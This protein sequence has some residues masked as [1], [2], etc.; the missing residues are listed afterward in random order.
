MIVVVVP[1]LGRPG[2]AA[3]VAESLATST[4]TP[5]RLVWVCSPGDTEQ[6]LACEQAGGEILMA[7]WEPGPGDF[8][9]KINHAFRRTEEP[10]LFQAA[11]DVEF[12]PG[13]DVEAL[14]VGMES[15]AGVVGT[16]DQANPL[17][18][19][20]GHATHS[21]IRREYVD[22]HGGSW[23]GPGTVFHEG[24]GHMWV[25]NELVELAKRRG[26]WAFASGSVV[27]HRHPIFDRT[28]KRDATYRRGEVT[29]RKDAA[30]FRE[31]RRLWEH[32]AHVAS[33]A[34]HSGETQSAP[35]PIASAGG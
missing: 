4:V 9:R 8:A 20:G 24:Y 35:A 17:V 13:W 6:V 27:R 26:R 10:W 16:N 3:R 15:A 18:K 21:L 12:T 19:R 28:V 2:N 31:R 33:G 7:H 29:A 23:D 30:L 34:L 5:H 25:E 14:R 11:D 32:V 1:V 22:E